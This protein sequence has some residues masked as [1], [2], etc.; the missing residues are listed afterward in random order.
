[1]GVYTKTF[2]TLNESYYYCNATEIVAMHD[3]L[4]GLYNRTLAFKD[5]NRTF[6][7]MKNNTGKVN[8]TKHYLNDLMK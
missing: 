3:V 4:P 2:C 7:R 5:F 6:F 1:M 8:K